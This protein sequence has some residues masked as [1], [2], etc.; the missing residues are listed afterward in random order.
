MRHGKAADAHLISQ[1]GHQDVERLGAGRVGAVV[2]EEANQTF[3]QQGGAAAP[4][5]M[6]A[7]LCQLCQQVK[8]IEANDEEVVA[9]SQHLVLGES[10]EVG[11]ACRDGCAGI[12]R[13]GSEE[14][15]WL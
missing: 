9:E 2:G 7:T 14:H 13:L 1:T 15:V 3:A 5:L 4:G 11:G 6:T 10:D 8:E 12:A